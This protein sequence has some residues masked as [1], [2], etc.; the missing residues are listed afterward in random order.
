ML[1][2]NFLLADLEGKWLGQF[3][4]NLAG[5]AIPGSISALQKTGLQTAALSSKKAINLQNEYYAANPRPPRVFFGNLCTFL[6]KIFNG[7]CTK[8]V[9]F[10]F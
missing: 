10:D 3:R 6:C 5:R 7:M 4:S 8:Q 2:C 9:F 1:V